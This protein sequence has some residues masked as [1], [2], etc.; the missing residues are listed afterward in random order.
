M[1]EE[2]AKRY[3][4]G[5]D[6]ATIPVTGSPADAM[7]V[8]H[9]AGLAAVEAWARSEAQETIREMTARV[10]ETARA[11]DDLEGRWRAKCA[12]LESLT[13]RCD[14]ALLRAGVANDGTEIAARIA[15]LGERCDKAERAAGEA[16][17]RAAGLKRRLEEENALLNEWRE[18]AFRFE[19]QRNKAMADVI[20][21]ETEVSDLRGKQPEAKAES[22]VDD[23]AKPFPVPGTQWRF[24]NDRIMTVLKIEGPE[25]DKHAVFADTS[26][27]SVAYMMGVPAWRYLGKNES[28]STAPAVVF[29]GCKVGTISREMVEEVLARILETE[30][31][32]AEHRADDR[33]DDEVAAGPDP[34]ERLELQTSDLLDRVARLEAATPSERQAFQRIGERAANDAIVNERL[35][36]LEDAAREALNRVSV[37][38]AAKPARPKVG[39]WVPYFAGSKPTGWQRF[40]DRGFQVA[41][42]GSG[43]PCPWNASRS[44]APPENGQ[45]PTLEAAK[46][47]ALAVLRTWADVE[48]EE[49]A[50]ARCWRCGKIPS[51]A[52][53]CPL[54]PS[55]PAPKQGSYQEGFE[56]GR[57]IAAAQKAIDALV[58]T[59][60]KEVDAIVRAH[61]ALDLRIAKARD[62]CSALAGY[63]ATRSI[64]NMAEISDRLSAIVHALSPS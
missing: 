13:R 29:K 34:L 31:T 38:E 4:E 62:A 60:R 57:E 58:E 42:V 55:E 63:L 11:R 20:K 43:E 10:Q 36:D 41:W 39:P 9:R 8:A 5:Y 49:P 19:R 33:P 17:E 54:C 3:C 35:N 18:R 51:R 30:T 23:G 47:A 15:V 37:L 7:A 27:A 25:D 28:P 64:E 61:A 6:K 21:A 26:R 2:A 16:G 59:H 24:G 50:L 40:D 48:G 56:H 45:A 1:S 46:A 32:S 12:E 22:R 53:G 44:F 52:R 14:V